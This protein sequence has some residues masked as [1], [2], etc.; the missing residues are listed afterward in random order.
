MSNRIIQR[1]HVRWVANQ[2]FELD[3][4]FNFLYIERLNRSGM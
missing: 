3:S 1:V 4:K 2:D